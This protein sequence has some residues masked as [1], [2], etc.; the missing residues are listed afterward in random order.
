MLLLFS[1]CF[2]LKRDVN[3]CV[4]KWQSFIIIGN[5]TVPGHLSDGV[6]E[7]GRS[8]LPRTTQTP[9]PNH[10]AMRAVLCVLKGKVGTSPEAPKHRAMRAVLCVLKGKVGTSPEA[11]KH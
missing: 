2:E 1:A 9:T 7:M 8:E 5:G 3:E 6:S 10:R 4:I 11:P